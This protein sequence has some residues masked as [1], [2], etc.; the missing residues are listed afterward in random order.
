MPEP[1]PRRDGI[2]EVETAE[3]SRRGNHD[4]DTAAD[5]GLPWSSAVEAALPPYHPPDK[6]IME[7]FGASS[8]IGP[9]PP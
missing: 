6:G 1:D 9:P 3:G 2:H 5:C 8:S 7:K 4:V